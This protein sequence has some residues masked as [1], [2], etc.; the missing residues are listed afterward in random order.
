MDTGGSFMCPRSAA[1][2]AVRVEGAAEAAEEA[3]SCLSST[4]FYSER[5]EIP[6]R[7][8]CEVR[9]GKLPD[10]QEGTVP[11][12]DRPAH[13]PWSVHFFAAMRAAADQRAAAA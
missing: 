5:C 9:Y 13:I 4:V 7:G 10:T 12:R 2:G 6:Y 1:R 8:G 11:H 3:R